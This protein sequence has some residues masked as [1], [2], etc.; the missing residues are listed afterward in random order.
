MSETPNTYIG[1]YVDFTEADS[2]DPKKY[3]WHRFEGLQ[4]PQGEQGI[5]GVGTDGKTTYLHIKYSNDGGKTF[6]AN[7][8]ETVGDYI[9]V[10]TDFNAKDPTSVSS[11]KWSK[12][13]GEK[14]DPGK[15]GIQGPT[16]PQGP[17]GPTGPTGP[18]GTKGPIQRTHDGFVTGS[19]DYSDG[20]KDTDKFIDIVVLNGQVYYC[21]LSYRSSSP[22][23]TDGHWTQGSNFD[24][25]ATKLLLAENA[26]ITMANSQQINII[27]GNTLWGSFRYA[28]TN[29]DYALWLGASNGASAPFAVTRG[30]V[31]KAMAGQI[32][33]FV[34]TQR[35]DPTGF[36]FYSL[37][38]THNSFGI[39][40]ACD[41]ELN[42]HGIRVWSGN[43][44]HTN[45]T[46]VD[47]GY[48]GALDSN[49][50]PSWFN[51]VVM[52]TGDTSSGGDDDVVAIYTSIYPKAGR[53]SYALKASVGDVL[54]GEGAFIGALR[55][56]I[57]TVSYS[58]TLRENECY[59]ICTNSSSIT[60]TLPSDPRIGQ[61]YF[62]YQAN[63]YISFSSTSSHPIIVRGQD[64]PSGKTNWYSNTRNQL[65]IFI[66]GDD[67]RWYVNYM[68]G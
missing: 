15:Q 52:I 37:Y 31:I 41:V 10:C 62:V 48:N 64:Y 34:I 36:V 57:T 60:L 49:E 56:N 25:V 68:N 21:S 8:G 53:R 7:N 54:L 14:G 45:Y 40:P 59:I 42:Y 26:T 5:P 18:R 23:V 1:T 35:K 55:P 38:A 65:S 24:L 20:T 3:T 30:G 46:E 27:D 63:A 39:I 50:N 22:S 47:I 13:K 61:L 11:Y 33:S 12:T 28:A 19:Y 32:G 67:G 29:D 9:G 16:G 4:G 51:G 43:N 66:Y 58:R 6:T 44:T 2:T 17:Q